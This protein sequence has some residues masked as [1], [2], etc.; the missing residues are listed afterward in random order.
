MII[1][2]K[3]PKNNE[4]KQKN[5][6][7]LGN[8]KK[9]DIL[10][11]IRRLGPSTVTQVKKEL[12]AETYLVSAVLSE[13]TNLKRLKTTNVKKG[14][15]IFYYLPEQKNQL[16]K[17]IDYL[18]EKDQGTVS[19]LKE[20]KVL[21]DKSQ[22]LFTRV[23]LRKIPDFAK[24]INIRISDNEIKVFWKYFLVSEEE[25]KQKI[26]NILSP[27]YKKE[28][29]T[30]NK[31]PTKKEKTEVNKKTKKQED[32]KKTEEQPKKEQPKVEE[33]KKETKEEQKLLI[34]DNPKIEE[35]LQNDKEFIRVA[36]KL[37]SQNIIIKE[38]SS[39][40]KGKDFNLVI[41]MNT[42][43][44][45]TKFFAKYKNKKKCNDGDLSTAVV[46][47]QSKQLPVAFITSGKLTKKTKEKTND[48]FHNITIVEGF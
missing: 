24:A 33:T 15:A 20:K 41:V 17:L 8:V 10:Q 46:L 26:R 45:K 9:E 34:E 32:V 42:P 25:A 7:S 36:K 5:N 13:L 22:E 23:S 12:G 6:N 14:T 21:E 3:I 39:V 1:N 44:G 28:Q 37:K 2:N 35:K 18:N 30:E 48:L 29:E 4:N 11:I 38:A 16:E 47:G 40:R 27:V 31:K 19:L 43:I